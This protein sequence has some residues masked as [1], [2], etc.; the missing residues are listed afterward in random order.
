M[1]LLFPPTL[2][3]IIGSPY[4]ID[5]KRKFEEPS[6]VEELTAKSAAL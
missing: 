2:Y 6:S 4:E 1:K 5:S 3:E